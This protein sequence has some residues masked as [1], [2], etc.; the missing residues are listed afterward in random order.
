MIVYWLATENEQYIFVQDLEWDRF[1]A[2]LIRNNDISQPMK[3]IVVTS[4]EIN[5]KHLGICVGDVLDC[6]SWLFHFNS[7][8]HSFIQ[9]AGITTLVKSKWPFCSFSLFDLV[10]NVLLGRSFIFSVIQYLYIWL[11]T[12]SLKGKYNYVNRHLNLPFS[13]FKLQ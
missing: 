12:N 7:W 3:M 1:I 9:L 10:S 8:L 6:I 5:V 11:K 4:I 13:D 2:K